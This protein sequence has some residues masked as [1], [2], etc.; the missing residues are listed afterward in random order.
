MK[1]AGIILAAGGST[2]MGGQNKLLQMV[3]GT[4]LVQKVV[5]SALN[6]NI[7]S[8]YVILGYQAAL[9][10]QCISN[11][12]V[13]WVENSD[14]S[15]GM[16]SSIKSGIEA[17]NTN[18]DGAMILL[19][20]MPFIE[21]IMINQLLAL[22]QK[23]KIVVPVK[24]GRQGNPVLFSSAFFADLK[25][26]GGDKGAKPIIKKNPD[27]VIIANVLTDTIFHDLDT[28]DQIKERI[29]A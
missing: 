26:L 13:N 20:D 16:A 5:G 6:S 18:Y 4:S 27:S 23:K 15:R 28:P 24:D 8:V 19:G 22:Y 14:W 12:S 11:K 17:L 29:S 9:I 10:R 21:P 3:D 25:L 2:R 7:E 1:I